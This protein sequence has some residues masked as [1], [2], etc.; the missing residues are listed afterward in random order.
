MTEI[1]QT[2]LAPPLPFSIGR[3]LS[4]F[5]GRAFALD[6]HLTVCFLFQLEQVIKQ[7]EGS[8]QKSVENAHRLY[9]S[10]M[11]PLRGEI[12]EIRDAMCKER[13]PTD[14]V[15]RRDLDE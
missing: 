14:L 9:T 1:W 15:D 3:Y 10:E 13:L 6:I 2:V 8:R 4:Q 11:L 7:A 12:N 5:I